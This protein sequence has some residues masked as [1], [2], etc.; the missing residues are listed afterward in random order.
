MSY[1]QRILLGYR[2]TPSKTPLFKLGIQTAK[3]GRDRL[4]F[5]IYNTI[6]KPE[7]GARQV[8]SRRP[9]FAGYWEVNL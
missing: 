9:F 1:C 3:P 5:R 7:K 4:F 8:A 6:Q 2:N